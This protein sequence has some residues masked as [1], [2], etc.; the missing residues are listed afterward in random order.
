MKQL[1]DELNAR[2]FGVFAQK[3][4]AEGTNKGKF[5]VSI[6]EN[7]SRYFLSNQ[8]YGDLNEDGTQNYRWARGAEMRKQISE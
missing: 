4:N 3:E 8:P 2:K 5:T 6:D 1:M 7:G